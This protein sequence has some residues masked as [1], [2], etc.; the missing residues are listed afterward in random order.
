MLRF[1]FIYSLLLTILT[2]VRV[3]AGTGVTDVPSTGPVP[4][5]PYIVLA[6][7][8]ADPQAT[9]KVWRVIQEAY[10]R[11]GISAEKHEV[12]LVRLYL[13]L[14]QHDGDA[15]LGGLPSSVESA[16]PS[17]IRVGPPILHTA[18]HVYAARDIEYR[19]LAGL[20]DWRITA[21]RGSFAVER[22]LSGM[23]IVWVNEAEQMIDLL[24]LKRVDVAVGLE[25]QM[26][27]LLDSRPDTPVR[28]IDFPALYEFRLYHYLAPHNAPLR[29][30]LG[31]ALAETLEDARNASG[32]KESPSPPESSP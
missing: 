12:P 29:D 24:L 17:M 26:T 13:M 19:G 8:N 16:Y 30:A 28:R 22:M 20:R 3:V 21:M 5:R 15:A 32:Q 2:T 10:R 23:D 18:Y 14:D 27:H 7:D 1:L 9:E 25:K 11:V 6:P 4:A 31:E